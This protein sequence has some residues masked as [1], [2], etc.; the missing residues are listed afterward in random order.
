MSACSADSDSTAAPGTEDGAAVDVDED[1]KG[2]DTAADTSAGQDATAQDSGGGSDASADSGAG[3]PDGGGGDTSD[4][5][6]TDAGVDDVSPSDAASSDTGAGDTSFGDT[7]LGDTGTGDTSGSDAGTPGAPGK[8]WAKVDP[9]TCDAGDAAWVRRAMLVIS[10]RLPA[11]G[12]GVLRLKVVARRARKG[13]RGR[14]PPEY[15]RWTSDQRRAPRH[16]IFDSSRA[17]SVARPSAPLQTAWPSTFET[18]LPPSQPPPK[19]RP[20]ATCWSLRCG[21]T[22]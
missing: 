10:G 21:S 12:R 20:C 8:Q 13:R 22:T 14:P 15:H 1:I 6:A 17:A 3:L 5:G 7:G 9:K 11:S 4:A 18:A 2:P 19:A 16:R